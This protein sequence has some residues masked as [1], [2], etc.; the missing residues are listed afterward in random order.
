MGGWDEETYQR[1]YYDR[2]ESYWLLSEGHYWVCD[3]DC[4]CE[5]RNGYDKIKTSAYFGKIGVLLRLINIPVH[6]EE[7][8]L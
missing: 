2:D 6:N 1:W 7:I 8:S 4:M 3:R 5:K